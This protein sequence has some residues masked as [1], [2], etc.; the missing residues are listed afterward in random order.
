MASFY[1]GG[2]LFTPRFVT[3]LEACEH[4]VSDNAR[5]RN[6]V[7]LPP[8]RADRDIDSDV[9]DTGDIVS[10]D[11]EG[12]EPAGKVEVGE[13][14]SETESED[15]DAREPPPKRQQHGKWRKRIDFK[16]NLRP[17]DSDPI[18][19]DNLELEGASEFEM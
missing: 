13:S 3:F 9:E 7:V 1:G 10:T 19:L 16:K 15:E 12:F 18:Q 17:D 6:L 8:D 14:C 4:A 5:V 2:G 11:E